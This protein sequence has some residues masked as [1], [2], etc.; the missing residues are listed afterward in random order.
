MSE[1]L[2]YKNYVGRGT[3][4][5]H[6]WSID[7]E[8]H[9]YLLMPLLFISL[10]FMTKNKE[11]AFKSIPYLII[12]IA[13]SCLFLRML[14]TI[15]HPFSHVNNVSSTH[16]RIDSLFFGTLISYFYHFHSIRLAECVNYN[17]NPLRF[18]SFILLLPC[19]IF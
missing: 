10:I 6:T 19:L 12:I 3:F 8:D 16:L 13:R 2:F 17:K 9:F 1:V 11:N 4:W 18:A 7:I 5:I 14:A 15:N